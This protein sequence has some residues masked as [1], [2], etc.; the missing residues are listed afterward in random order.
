MNMNKKSIDMYSY[1][2][3]L[4]MHISVNHSFVFPTHF[5]LIPNN[6]TI[7]IHCIASETDRMLY[8]MTRKM[9]I[10]LVHKFTD[11]FYFF[12]FVG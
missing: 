8:W 3:T 7:L 2:T 6:V 5:Q 10:G 4:R 12:S 1:T 11:S 9:P